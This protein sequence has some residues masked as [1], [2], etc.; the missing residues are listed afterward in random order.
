[1]SEVRLV[2][3]D[4]F[5]AISGTPHGA[6]AD[7]VVAALSTEPETIEE[8]DAGL[9][10]LNGPASL[11]WLFFRDTHVRADGVRKLKQA[12]PTLSIKTGY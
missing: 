12:W 8:L 9:A 1:M 11:K 7:A 3:R 6:F 10:N 2:I 4:A 5:R